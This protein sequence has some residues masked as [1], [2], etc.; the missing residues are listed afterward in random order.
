MR[1]VRPNDSVASLSRNMP[2]PGPKE[3]WFRVLN[4]MAPGAQPTPGQVVKLVV[5]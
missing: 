4:G 5:E 3:E 2:M 1:V